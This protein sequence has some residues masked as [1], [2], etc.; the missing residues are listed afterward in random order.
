[1][2]KKFV[3]G[4]DCGGSG[5]RAVAADRHGLQI[6]EIIKCKLIQGNDV[7]DPQAVIKLI[8]V[9]AK[10]EAETPLAIAV[11]AKRIDDKGKPD[12]TR[13]AYLY[14]LYKEG[15]SSDVPIFVRND[16]WA[17]LRAGTVGDGIVIA[18]GTG[19]NVAL[20]R[21]GQEDRPNSSNL[22][23]RGIVAQVGHK[24]E[25]KEQLYALLPCVLAAW[26]A[27]ESKASS[28]VERSIDRLAKSAAKLTKA[29]PNLPIILGGGVVEDDGFALALEAK[30]R[31]LSPLSIVKRIAEKPV[32]GAA[33]LALELLQ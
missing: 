1:M 22:G 2:T 23:A 25:T 16:T 20:L 32:M 33:K 9:I 17:I 27:G 10:R 14:R 12:R 13:D 18:V 19:S 3:I 11:C 24:V 28:A 8:R 6:D 7:P 26:T 21:E 4:V 5:I 15:L 29:A 30:V 31:E